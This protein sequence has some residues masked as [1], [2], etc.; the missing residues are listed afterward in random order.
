MS[1]GIDYE[2]LVD[3]AMRILIYNILTS[4]EKHGLISKHHYHIGFNTTY[5]GVEIPGH[6][7]AKY[8]QEIT[9]ALQNQ[10]KDLRVIGD[11]FSVKLT[12]HGIE[13]RLVVPFCAITSFA[14]PSE[15]FMLKMQVDE[16]GIYG[17]G[18]FHEMLNSHFAPKDIELKEEL[19]DNV[20]NFMDIKK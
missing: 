8:P 18:K 19:E 17:G 20:I 16:L 3:S 15:N 2:Y 1:F 6:L 12:F 7:L 14:D 4:I 11:Y 13:E 5:D 9:I 10:F